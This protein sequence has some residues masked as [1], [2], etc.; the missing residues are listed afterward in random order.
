[1]RTMT[2]E[3]AEVEK[4]IKL[5]RAIVNRFGAGANG[6]SY[7]REGHTYQVTDQENG[8]YVRAR[9]L[10]SGRIFVTSSHNPDAR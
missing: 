5:R 7:R 1:M 9:F 4:R 6:Y 3:Q 10:D 8:A 2:N